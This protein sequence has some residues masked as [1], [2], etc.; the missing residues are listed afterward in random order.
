[1]GDVLPFE[2]DVLGGWED[3]V[4]IEVFDVDTRCPGTWCGDNVVDEALD[5]DKIGRPSRFVS[6]EVNEVSPNST[7]DSVWVCLLVPVVGHDS[8]VGG[9]L[10]GGNLSWMDQLASICPLHVVFRCFC[11]CE[12]LK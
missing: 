4:D 7:P 5:G 11:R 6:G 1:L 12:S 10:P 8:D 9:S 2:S 3:V